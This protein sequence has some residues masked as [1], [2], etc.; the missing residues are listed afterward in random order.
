MYQSP[1][2]LCSALLQRDAPGLRRPPGPPPPPRRL[3]PTAAPRL[4]SPRLPAAASAAREVA[5][6]CSRTGAPPFLA[7][8]AAAATWKR[9]GMNGKPGAAGGGVRPKRFLF[10]LSRRLCSPCRSA[11]AFSCLGLAPR[12]V[13][14]AACARFPFNPSCLMPRF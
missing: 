7:E 13:R 14:A 3:S 5:R 11:L 12:P 6:S 10:S 2:R 4:P 1:R 9:R 8:N